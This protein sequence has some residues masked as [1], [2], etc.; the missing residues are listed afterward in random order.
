MKKIINLVLLILPLVGIAQKQGSIWYFGTRY[1][2]DFSSGTPIQT[3]GGMT[4]YANGQ[5]VGNMGCSSLCDANGKLLFYSDNAQLWNCNHKMMPHGDSLTCSRATIQ[6]SIIV[7]KPGSN[8][9]FYVFTCEDHDDFLYPQITKGYCYSVVD[10]CL[11]SARGDIINGQKNI[12]L[13]DSASQQ[14]CVCADMQEAGYWIVGHKAVSDQIWAWH[15]TA[16][17]ISSPVISIISKPYDLNHLSTEGWLK[18]NPSGTTLAIAITDTSR[19][20]FLLYDFNSSTG[21]LSNLR[22]ATIDSPSGNASVNSLEFSPDGSKLFV[23]L[24][25]TVDQSTH[26]LKPKRLY[27]YDM[28]AGNWNSILASRKTLCSVLDSFNTAMSGLQLGPDG[29][30]YLCTRTS[31][32][33]VGRINYP[34]L[35]GTA[36]GFDSVAI[37]LSSPANGRYFDFPGI[38]AGYKYINGIPCVKPASVNH[39]DANPAIE[40]FPNPV[41]QTGI[42]RISGI[43]DLQGLQL[44]IADAFGRTVKKMVLNSN[45]FS[46]DLS[47]ASSGVYS[48]QLF[49]KGGLIKVGTFVIN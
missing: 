42:L 6:G 25:G 18:F 4:G 21:L 44:T 7:P 49:Q 8:H 48:Y 34:N 14:I 41:K 27:Q 20:G 5:L 37:I 28:N 31:P 43:S 16:A 26:P 1:G 32:G 36:A 22:R 29:K 10:M 47:T 11:D 33:R 19:S 15:L 12:Q 17:G 40:F 45:P 13:T 9:I 2:L 24:F 30:I 23:S 3:F 38:I 39:S 35:S 46:I